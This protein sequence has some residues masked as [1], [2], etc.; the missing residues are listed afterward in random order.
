MYLLA[1]QLITRLLAGYRVASL[2]PKLAAQRLVLEV[3]P[4]DKLQNLPSAR[5][6]K[7]IYLILAKGPV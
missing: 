3:A 4:L 5:P 1:S 6:L 2:L 7:N